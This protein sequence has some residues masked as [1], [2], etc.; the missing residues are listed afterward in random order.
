M[1]VF[2]ISGAVCSGAL[3]LLLHQLPLIGEWASW[4]VAMQLRVLGASTEFFAGLPG[5]YPDIRINAAGLLIMYGIVVAG[6]VWSMLHPRIGRTCFMVLA[7]AAFLNWAHL[8]HQRNQRVAFVLYDMRE[9]VLASMSHGRTMDLLLDEG[10]EHSDRT[11][12]R[13]EQHQRGEGVRLAAQARMDQL[14]SDGPH[15]MASS[16]MGGGLWKGQGMNVAFIGAGGIPSHQVLQMADVVVLL[17]DAEPDREDVP[18]LLGSGRTVVIHAGVRPAVRHAV[19]RHATG[20]GMAFHDMRG[21]G[22][23]ILA[24]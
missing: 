6:A 23:F 9:G 4:L 3:L 15:V 18:A 11:T 17:P 5:A 8:A 1:V 10:A 20:T 14:W 13:L 24:R 12:A 19:R 16:M 22:A 21:Q 2:Q 7:V